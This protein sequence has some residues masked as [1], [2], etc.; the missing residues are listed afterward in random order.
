MR[1]GKVDHVHAVMWQGQ[2][3]RTDPIVL[4]VI[5]CVLK[6]LQPHQSRQHEWRAAEHLQAQRSRS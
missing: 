6:E 5:L 4:E 1:A 2:P 3:Q